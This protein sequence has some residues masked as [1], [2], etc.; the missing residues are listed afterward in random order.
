VI[1][2]LAGSAAAARPGHPHRID[3]PDQLAGVG[4]L[5]R[6]QPGRQVPTATVADGV[7]LGGQPTP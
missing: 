2:S 4:I 1:G 3:Q 5:P 7:E 6:S